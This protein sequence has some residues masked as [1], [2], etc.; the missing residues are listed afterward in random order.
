MIGIGVL[1]LDLIFYPLFASLV[2][3]VLT[4][5]LYSFYCFDYKIAAI[6][7]G[8]NKSIQF[9]ESNWSFYSGFGFPFAIAM[10]M[11]P[12]ILSSA[13]YAL[14]FPLLVCMSVEAEPLVF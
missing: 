9:F 13:V 11:F 2:K 4:S 5:W 1:F 7:L 8:S 10:F 12:S 14:L 3:L 6:G